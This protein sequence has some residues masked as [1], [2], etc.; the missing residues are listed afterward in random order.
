[1]NID[2]NAPG[3]VA[4]VQEMALAHI[5]MRRDAARRTNRLPFLKLLAHLSN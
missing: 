3:N 4:Q 1:M 2:L 5:A